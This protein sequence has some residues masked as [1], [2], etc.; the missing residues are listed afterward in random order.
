MDY[1]RTLP[2]DVDWQVVLD[3]IYISS[4]GGGI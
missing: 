2:M 3:D 1:G 4:F